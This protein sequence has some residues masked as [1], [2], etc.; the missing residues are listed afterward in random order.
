MWCHV[1]HGVIDDQRCCVLT[2]IVA[3]DFRDVRGYAGS[4]RTLRIH[5]LDEPLR[6]VALLG[7]YRL[8]PHA[9]ERQ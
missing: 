5:A 3:Q 6:A 9:P 4:E 8:R 1:H 2:E 7:Q